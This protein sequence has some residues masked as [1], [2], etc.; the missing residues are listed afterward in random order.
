MLQLSSEWLGE[1]IG[2]IGANLLTG[3]RTHQW[4]IRFRKPGIFNS[5]EFRTRPAKNGIQKVKSR[6]NHAAKE[7]LFFI[8]KICVKV[9]FSKHLFRPRLQISDAVLHTLRY[10]GREFE[11]DLT[12]SRNSMYIARYFLVSRQSQV[13]IFHAA[14]CV[15]VCTYDKTF[16]HRIDIEFNWVVGSNSHSLY[17]GGRK[18]TW[19]LCSRLKEIKIQFGI[20]SQK[21]AQ[22]FMTPQ[23]DMQI[24]CV[25]T[26]RITS[27]NQTTDSVALL[28]VR[29]SCGLFSDLS[30]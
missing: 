1:N 22:Y 4:L 19:R 27:Q 25:H 13:K 3:L 26:S 15:C 2:K 11:I 30:H 7:T 12:P 28:A 24:D 14:S 21:S 5:Q 18:V 29:C 20:H 8:C 16:P 23:S 9:I 10:K 17:K 6:R